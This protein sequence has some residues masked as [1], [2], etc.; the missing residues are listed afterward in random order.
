[1]SKEECQLWYDGLF[2]KYPNTFRNLKYIECESGWSFIIEALCNTIE[3]HIQS[4]PEEV[5]DEICAVQIKEKFGG[6]RFYMQSSTPYIDGAISMAESLSYYY[7]EYCGLPGDRG[8]PKAGW[9]K[10]LCKDCYNKYRK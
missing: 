10:T 5:R 6:L 2:S 7:C 4:L 8:N 9:I 1:M 3:K